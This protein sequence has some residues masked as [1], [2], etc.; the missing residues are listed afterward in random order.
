MLS[1][2]VQHLY[3]VL[4]ASG[5][6]LA[7]LVS[8]VVYRSNAVQK[9][10]NITLVAILLAFAFSAMT[11]ALLH[12]HLA[13]NYPSMDSLSEPFQLLIGPFLYF[14]LLRLNRL[15]ITGRQLKLHLTPF[16][17]VLITLVVTLASDYSDFFSGILYF[18]EINW[19]ALGVYF[20]I[21]YYY[22]LCQKAFNTYKNTLK[23]SCSSLDKINQA[24]IEQSLFALLLGYSAITLMYLLN[25]G[26]YFLPVNKSLAVVL[27]LISYFIVY[28]TLRLPQIIIGQVQPIEQTI[29]AV[30]IEPSNKNKKY[31]KSGLSDEKSRQIYRLL[32]LHMQDKKAFLD[33]ELSIQVLAEQL[34]LSS[35]HLSQ[36]INHQ[37]NGNFY[38]FIN[39]LRIE[40]VKIQLRHD[41]NIGR[42]ILAIA[43][44]AGFNSKATFNR[45]FKEKL[46]QTPSQYRKSVNNTIKN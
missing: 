16:F 6:L 41:A 4:I 20:Q 25:H 46:Q 8:L 28:K 27:S 1:A 22:F 15:E 23:Q 7:M 43:L 24:W 2:I 40:E 14:Y 38:D 44:D 33:A 19:L 29:Q 34:N 11:N 10:K 17:L 36:V 42:S 13:Q 9:S 18:Q 31:Q 35:H 39:D 26:L 5:V 21:G 37:Q 12:N 3:T 45:I 30:E 32:Q